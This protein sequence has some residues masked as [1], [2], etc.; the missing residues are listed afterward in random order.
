MITL[1]RSAE[2]INK[3]NIKNAYTKAQKNMCPGMC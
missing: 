1:G 2:G 3:L